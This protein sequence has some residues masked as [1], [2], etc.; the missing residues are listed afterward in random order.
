MGTGQYDAWEIDSA[1]QTL[2]KIIGQKD[3]SESIIVLSR[4]NRR[5]NALERKCLD[6][7]DYR[8]SFLSIHSAKGKEADYVLLLGCISGKLGFPSEFVNGDEIDI[9]RNS[10]EVHDANEKIEEERRLLYVAITRC[11]KKLY[12]FS[13]N[14]AKSRFISEIEPLLEASSSLR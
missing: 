5:K 2:L 6:L 7:T 1:R 10:A 11:K 4:T 12:I 9:A 8:I 13:S 3:P 14:K